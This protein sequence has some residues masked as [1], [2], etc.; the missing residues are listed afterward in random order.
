VSSFTLYSYSSADSRVW[1]LGDEC[2]RRDSLTD[3]KV[4]GCDF[5]EGEKCGKRSKEVRKRERK[6]FEK[7]VSDVWPSRSPQ[8]HDGTRDRDAR[9]CIE[10]WQLRGRGGLKRVSLCQSKGRALA[11]VLRKSNAAVRQASGRL[12][13]VIELFGA[14]Q[15]SAQSASRSRQRQ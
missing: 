12:T 4:R 7:R 14:T 5:E 3:F 13:I 6:R 8:R 10:I 11:Y 9:Q 2:V 15:I 1:K